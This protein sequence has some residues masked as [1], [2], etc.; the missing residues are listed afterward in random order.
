MNT[1]SFLHAPR[2]AGLRARRR[3]GFTLIETMVALSIFAALGYGL[4]IVVRIGNHSQLTVT[5]MA[6]EDRSLRAATDTLLAD[7]RVA[8]DTSIAVAVLADGN[9]QVQLQQPIDAGGASTWGVY[10][11]TLGPN[12]AAQN[13]AG[14]HVQYTVKNVAIGGGAIDKQFVRQELDVAGNVQREKVL[15]TSLR[16]GA[17]APAGFQMVKVGSVWQVTLSTVGKTEGQAGIREV[18]HVKARN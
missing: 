2:R 6:A 12:A 14:W 1:R 11:R 5:R 8:S 7:L 15:A 17:Q 9:H 16:G 10:D 18:F 4:A 3:A 13:Q